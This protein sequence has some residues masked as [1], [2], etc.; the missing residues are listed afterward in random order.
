MHQALTLLLP[1]SGQEFVTVMEENALWH[2][3]DFNQAAKVLG[4]HSE[5]PQENQRA[6]RIGKVQTDLLVTVKKQRTHVNAFFMFIPMM[7]GQIPSAVCRWGQPPGPGQSCTGSTEGSAGAW[8][9]LGLFQP[10]SLHSLTQRSPHA[11]LP[12]SAA[13]SQKTLFTAFVKAKIRAGS[14]PRA[15]QSKRMALGRWERLRG[16]GSEP[17]AQPGLGDT[18][19]G[20]L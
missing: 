18:T 14:V 5:L 1:C 20:S 8:G 4:A 7:K 2:P 13:H 19:G 15:L 11:S 3:E 6:V 12:P 17:R 9:V 10:P 16:T